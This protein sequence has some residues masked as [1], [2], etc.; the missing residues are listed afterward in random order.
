V[1][2]AVL[3]GLDLSALGQCA[4]QANPMLPQ[5][6]SLTVPGPPAWSV[7]GTLSAGPGMPGRCNFP[8][9]C[10]ESARPCRYLIVA[11]VSI[12]FPASMLGPPPT[13]PLL[14]VEIAVQPPAPTPGGALPPPFRI[15]FVPPP[16]SV[17]QYLGWV[18]TNY[19]YPIELS[20]PCGGTVALNLLFG[21]PPG[22]LSASGSAQATCGNC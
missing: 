19:N 7:V 1:L 22:A 20:P 6:P 12:T 14:T 5:N 17:G 15:S 16:S 21:R 13:F 18:T 10:N 2:A 3:F 8:P 11:N 4:C 9:F